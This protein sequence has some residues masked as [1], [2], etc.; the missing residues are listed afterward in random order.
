M[1]RGGSHAQYLRDIRG[2]TARHGARDALEVK[3][4]RKLRGMAAGPAG[5]PKTTKV[6]SEKIYSIP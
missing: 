6:D 2:C 1:R 5:G 4:D 3:V